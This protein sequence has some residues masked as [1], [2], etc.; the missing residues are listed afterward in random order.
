MTAEVDSKNE[1]TSG[2]H[3]G[4][5]S[6]PRTFPGKWDLSAYQTT[7]PRSKDGHRSENPGSLDERD[8]ASA[9]SPAEDGSDWLPEPFPEPRTFP[10]R[11]D[12]S[13]LG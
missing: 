11:W 4:P 10:S 9:A 8:S 13:E 6:Q 2:W 1:S 12:M 5:F 7:D 3:L